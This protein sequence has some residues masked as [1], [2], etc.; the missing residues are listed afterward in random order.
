MR[1]LQ[2]RRR[3]RNFRDK[4]Y[5]RRDN[6]FHTGSRTLLYTSDMSCA[7]KAPSSQC[8]WDNQCL[9]TF[10]SFPPFG[11]VPSV[12]GVHPH[13]REQTHYLCDKLRKS[14]C[15]RSHSTTNFQRHNPSPCSWAWDTISDHLA[16]TL[17]RPIF[18]T[19]RRAK[20]VRSHFV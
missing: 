6:G 20:R 3:C 15:R 7:C 5:A 2:I 19:H 17:K 18:C 8:T 9:D 12:H 16:P 4:V 1:K 10:A 14:F 11:A 13:R